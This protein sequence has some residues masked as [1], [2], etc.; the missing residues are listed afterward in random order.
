[1]KWLHNLMKGASLTTALFIF[2]ACYG[3]PE[4][5]ND[6]DVSITVVSAEDNAPLKDV[7]VFTRV[8]HDENL[9]WNLCGY[10][11]ESGKLETYVGVASPNDPEFRFKAGDVTYQVKDTVIAIPS[12]G[13]I[14][15][16]LCKAE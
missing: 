15:I 6:R 10:T 2:Q 5:M 9:D 11:D 1:M 14:E 3:T 4:W 12:N 16:K 7:E 8:Y 13:V